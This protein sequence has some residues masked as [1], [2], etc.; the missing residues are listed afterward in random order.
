[1]PLPHLHVFHPAIRVAPHL[2]EW[3]GSVEGLLRADAT[4]DGCTFHRLVFDE[5]AAFDVPTAVD[6]VNRSRG[7]VIV[8]QKVQAR[9]LDRFR[10][11]VQRR[12]SIYPLSPS[13]AEDIWQACESAR[14]AFEDGDPRISLRELIAYLIIR[15]LERQGKWGGTALNK[16][17]LGADDLPKGGF[18]KECS[19]TREI[20]QVADVLYNAS[21]LSGKLGDGQTKYALGPVQIVQPILDSRAFE[22]IRSLQNYFSRDRIFVSA[23]L[24][25]YNDA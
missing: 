15:K 11:M 14:Q 8:I 4:W 16:N 9:L 10:S 12:V 13:C 21:V 3:L 24:L 23:D 18:P 25:D 6:F 5:Q 17:F 19:N 1:M 2:P 7:P 22:G 20:L